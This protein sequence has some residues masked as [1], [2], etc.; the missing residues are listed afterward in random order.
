MTRT[1]NC[2]ERGQEIFADLHRFDLGN[3]SPDLPGKR[4]A[5]L[6]PPDRGAVKGKFPAAGGSQ[7]CSKPGK[8]RA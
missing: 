8:A 4:D 1:E 7:G 5:R 3:C 6:P 2:S